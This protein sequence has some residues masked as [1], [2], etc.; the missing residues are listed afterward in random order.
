MM[1]TRDT[2]YLFKS[3]RRALYRQ[4]NLQ[5][6]A[7][8]RGTVVELAWNRSWVAAE[9][10]EPGTIVAGTPVVFVL[11]DRPYALFVPV[12]AGE[13]VEASWEDVSLRFRVALGTWVRPAGCGLE[14]YTAG[15]RAA[16]GHA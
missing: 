7:A 11:T 15:L 13:V 5:L 10:F 1:R 12:R 6:L 8:E 16:Q 3:A 2:V 4:Q 14:A 9:Y